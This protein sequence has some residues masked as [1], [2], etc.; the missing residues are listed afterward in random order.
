MMNTIDTETELGLPHIFSGVKS[1]KFGG[2]LKRLMIQNSL[3]NQMLLA[4]LQTSSDLFQSVDGTT[5]SRWINN[6]TTPSFKKQVYICLFLGMNFNDMMHKLVLPDK[7]MGVFNELSKIFISKTDYSRFSYIPYSND[8]S[9]L[10]IH[11]DINEMQIGIIKKFYGNFHFYR[12]MG[13]LSILDD[14][15]TK[16]ICVLKKHYTIPNSHICYTNLNRNIFISGPDI[17]LESGSVF[18]HLSY[19]SGMSEFISILGLFIIRLIGDGRVDMNMNIYSLTRERKFNDLYR[20][21]LY[22]D[23]VYENNS[24]DNGYIAL[25]RTPILNVLSEHNLLHFTKLVSI[26]HS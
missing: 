10:S 25:Y 2:L 12:S 23:L 11:E 16:Y 1:M 13:F 24:K 14:D 9:E 20:D 8:I 17:T 21:R 22:S 19:F 18:L 26:K 4:R 7:T 15:Q 6:K 5:L 3:N